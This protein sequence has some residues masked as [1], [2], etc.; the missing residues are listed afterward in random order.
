MLLLICTNIRVPLRLRVNSRNLST[1]CNRPYSSFL[2]LISTL[3]LLDKLL[4][5]FTFFLVFT[6]TWQIQVTLGD[7]G[8]GFSKPQPLFLPVVVK[9]GE[10][11]PL[12]LPLVRCL[13]L[14][15]VEKEIQ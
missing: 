14:R 5:C 1:A 9:N 13:R 3:R 2:K 4:V 6:F 15:E 8:S 7:E 11:P 10:A 12:R